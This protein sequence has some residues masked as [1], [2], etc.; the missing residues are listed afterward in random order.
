M[1]CPKC[2][3]SSSIVDSRR[4]DEGRS[5]FRR[6]VCDACEHRWNT[7][8]VLLEDASS[9]LDRRENTIMKLRNLSSEA[10]AL[11]KALESLSTQAR[12]LVP[13]LKEL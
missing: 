12:E 7:R 10:R 8:E 5:V 11:M 9:L 2:K 3:G 6:R 13:D 4:I 1:I